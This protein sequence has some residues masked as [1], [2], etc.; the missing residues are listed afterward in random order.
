M[1]IGIRSVEVWN[2]QWRNI[3]DHYQ[4][5]IRHAYYIRAILNGE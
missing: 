5:D 4:Q 1:N 2:D 3:F